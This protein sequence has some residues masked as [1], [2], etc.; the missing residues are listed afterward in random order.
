MLGCNFLDS[1]ISIGLIDAVE[2]RRSVGPAAPKQIVL[3][4]LE[5]AHH[6]F[7]GLLAIL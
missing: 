1:I 4:L 7:I 5:L 2:E 6:G 3:D